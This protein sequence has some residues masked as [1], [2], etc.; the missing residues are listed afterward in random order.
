MSYDFDGLTDAFRITGSPGTLGFTSGSLWFYPTDDTL[1]D[2]VLFSEQ[3]TAGTSGFRVLYGSTSAADKVYFFRAGDTVQAI[4]TVAATLNAWNHV[5]WSYN[6]YTSPFKYQISL[7][8]E[9]L[10]TQNIGVPSGLATTTTVIGRLTLPLGAGSNWFRGRIAE[11][12]V[13]YDVLDTFG[14]E[15]QALSKGYSP[16]CVHPGEPTIGLLNYWPFRKNSNDIVGGRGLTAI[17]TPTLS[18]HCRI[19]NK[20][21][22][23]LVG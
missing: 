17:G 6:V 9:T 18:E 1:A 23:K 21:R 10:Q 16:L 22:G 5:F 4:S 8:G 12:A 19:F 15:Y 20:G 7:N 2:Q 3:N 14:D 11:L 13:W